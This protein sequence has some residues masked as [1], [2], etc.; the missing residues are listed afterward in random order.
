MLYSYSHPCDPLVDSGWEIA[1]V[2]QLEQ[3]K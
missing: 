3:R 2:G 1:D